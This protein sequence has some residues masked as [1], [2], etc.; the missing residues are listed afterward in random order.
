MSSSY[1][2]N[3]LRKSVL[4][5]ALNSVS[6]EGSVRLATK[7]NYQLTASYASGGNFDNRATA[8]PGTKG[9]VVGTTANLFGMT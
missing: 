6:A 4:G 9:N 2:I 5:V 7:G 3:N 1:T 8:V